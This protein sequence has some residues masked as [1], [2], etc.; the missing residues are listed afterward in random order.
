M[1]AAQYAAEVTAALTEDWD[2][3][4]RA[5]DALARLLAELCEAD[6]PLPGV[7]AFTLELLDEIGSAPQLEHCVCCRRDLGGQEPV[8]FSSLEGGL[9]CRDC[10][11]ALAEKRQVPAAIVPVLSGVQGAGT[12]VCGPV[13]ELLN[14][15]LAHLMGRR[16]QLAEALLSSAR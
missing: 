16:P 3:H 1:H 12:E 14:Y 2:P 6:R 8:Y 7:V 15:H 13:F 9:V 11:G 5:F 10:E 4:P